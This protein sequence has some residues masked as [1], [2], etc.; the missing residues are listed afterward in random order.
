MAPTR[1]VMHLFQ[2]SWLGIVV[3]YQVP[4]PYLDCCILPST[5]PYLGTEQ[6]CR[7]V[8]ALCLMLLF[9]MPHSQQGQGTVCEML[10]SKVFSHRHTGLSDKLLLIDGLDPH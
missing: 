3:S 10:D 7:V 9:T 5:V 8:R 1:P 4:V 6:L 2:G